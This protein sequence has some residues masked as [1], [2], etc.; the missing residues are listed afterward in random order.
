MSISIRVVK[1]IIIWI[2]IIFLEQ[3]T[4]KSSLTS[5]WP[6]ELKLQEI[7]ASNG[8]KDNE[9]NFVD[10]EDDDDDVCTNFF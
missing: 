10:D 9:D 7:E 5:S 2:F 6:K 8:F 4:K 3:L 1:Y